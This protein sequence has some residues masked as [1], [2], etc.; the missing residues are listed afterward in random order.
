MNVGAGLV[1]GSHKNP[2][3]HKSGWTAHIITPA[4]TYATTKSK[5]IIHGLVIA[6]RGWLV[7]VPNLKQLFSL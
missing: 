6:G 1:V 3:R 7:G 5:Y 2:K 4:H